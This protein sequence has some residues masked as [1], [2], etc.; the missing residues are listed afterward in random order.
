MLVNRYVNALEVTESEL[1]QILIPHKS[2]AGELISRVV[3][4][5]NA[6]LHQ[7]ISA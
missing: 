3:A 5:V 2:R 7:D 4:R 1:C 6:N